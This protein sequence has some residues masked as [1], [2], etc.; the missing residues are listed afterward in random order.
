MQAAGDGV[1][2]FRDRCAQGTAVSAEVGGAVGSFQGPRGP[3]GWEGG[4][5]SG[6]WNVV[7]R[8]LTFFF[9]ICKSDHMVST[10]LC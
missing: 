8:F 7:E 9:L 5:E 4:A 10:E 3:H 1:I 2:P 6:G